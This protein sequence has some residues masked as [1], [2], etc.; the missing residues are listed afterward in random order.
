[1]PAA[2]LRNIK[3]TVVIFNDK[4]KFRQVMIVKPEAGD[5]LPPGLFARMAIYF[6]QPVAE[7]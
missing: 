4:G 5:A 2:V 3:S 1:M 6:F 7:H